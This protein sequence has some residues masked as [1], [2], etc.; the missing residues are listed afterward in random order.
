MLA[1][2]RL[3]FVHGDAMVSISG[4]ADR[5]MHIEVGIVDKT[6]WVGTY[7]KNRRARS[8]TAAMP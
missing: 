5:V 4:I 2:A 8:A 3:F 6:A 1:T 7:M